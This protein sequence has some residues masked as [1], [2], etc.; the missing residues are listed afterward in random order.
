MLTDFRCA[1]RHI[2]PPGATAGSPF[3]VGARNR[4]SLDKRGSTHDFV[5]QR[6]NVGR[7]LG[8][9]FGLLIVLSCLLIA[10]GLLSMSQARSE[11][12]RIVKVNVEKVRISNGMLDDNANILIALGTL[13]MVSNS[14]LNQQALA[15]IQEHRRHY[16]EMRRQLE[17]FPATE[18]K[19]RKLRAEIDADRVVAGKLNDQVIALGAA[20]RNAEA[21][22]VLSEQARPAHCRLAGQ[23]P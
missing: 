7:R 17:A 19:I 21:Q 22:A 12:D 5:L 18:E 14:E 13:T 10:A 2:D 20:N 6:Y 4:S 16:A 9:A 23:D 3:R 8:G 15:D 1:F 11:L